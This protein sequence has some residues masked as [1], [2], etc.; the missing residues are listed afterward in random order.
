MI[1]NFIIKETITGMFSE[2]GVKNYLCRVSVHR[3]ALQ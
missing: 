3:T 2:R 1:K